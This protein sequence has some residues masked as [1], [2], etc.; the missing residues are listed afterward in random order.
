[1]TTLCVA[2]KI[3]TDG[4]CLLIT[5]TVQKKLRT[6]RTYMFIK[7]Y[8]PLLGIT[9]DL[10]ESYVFIILFISFMITISCVFQFNKCR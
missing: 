10:L 4:F 7:V 9:K 8:H 2:L 3:E 5:L 6:M 1:M